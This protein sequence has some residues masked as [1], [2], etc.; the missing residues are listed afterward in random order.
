MQQSKAHVIKK[1]ANN[2][3]ATIAARKAEYVRYRYGRPNARGITLPTLN[4]GT[5]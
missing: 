3:K 5:R 1:A 4:W 2:L